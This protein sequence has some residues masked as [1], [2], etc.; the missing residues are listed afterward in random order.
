MKVCPRTSGWPKARPGKAGP[1]GT[2]RLDG[3]SRAP[4]PRPSGSCEPR[5]GPFHRVLTEP[6]PVPSVSTEDTGFAAW[7][8]HS[9]M[10]TK[11]LDRAGQD[12]RAAAIPGGVRQKAP[13]H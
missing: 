11:L 7:W 12:N 4:A 9:V 5:W 6:N 2:G 8:V 3:R 1:P 10:S 13:V